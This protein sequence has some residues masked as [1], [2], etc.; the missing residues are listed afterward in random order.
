MAKIG[1]ALGGGGAKA[2]AH[3]GVLMGLE[4]MGIRPLLITGTSAG[5]YIGAM[6]AAGIDL[7]I[8]AKTFPKLSVGK[9]YGFPG[10]DPAVSSNSKY[11]DYFRDILGNITFD[12]LQIPLAV[13]ATDL[14]SRREVILDEGDVV[15]AVMASA[16][17]PLVFPPIEKD[18]MVLVDGGVMNNVPFDV[19]RA[20]GATFVI[21]VDLTNTAPFGTKVEVT[22]PN[23]GLL[24]KAMVLARNRRLWQIMSTLSDINSHRQLQTRLAISQPELL[25]QPYLG[26]IGLFDTHRW[27][28]GME[29]GRTAVYESADKLEKLL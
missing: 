25:I 15:T 29:A 8:I 9:M 19:A 28:E 22:K 2:S 20:R 26:T 10:S 6:Y 21:A 7:N 23:T 17:L 1:L 13:I 5:A 4:E 16:S 18:E 14:I 11:H 24:E 3:I 12:A 27:E